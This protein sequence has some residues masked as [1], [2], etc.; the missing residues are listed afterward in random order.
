MIL[1][2]MTDSSQTEKPMFHEGEFR[3]EKGNY[4]LIFIENQRD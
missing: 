1:L 4:E 3:G 2:D